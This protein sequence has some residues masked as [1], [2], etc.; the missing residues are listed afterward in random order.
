MKLLLNIPDLVFKIELL[1][2]LSGFDIV[3]LDNAILN[4]RYR[5]RIMDKLENAIIKGSLD[6][7]ATNLMLK[8]MRLRKLYLT[9]IRFSSNICFTEYMDMIN[10]KQLVRAKAIKFE[11]NCNVTDG[12]FTSIVQNCLDLKT[13]SINDCNRMSDVSIVSM[14]EMAKNLQILVL[15]ENY[16]SD[17]SLMSVAKNC[18]KLLKLSLI[19]CSSISDK[20]MKAVAEYC[21]ALQTLFLHDCDAITD[22]GLLAIANSCPE[23]RHVN[24]K[25][26]V[27]DRVVAAIAKTCRNL[28]SFHVINSNKVTDNSISYLTSRCRGVNVMN[29]QDCTKIT[30]ASILSLSRHC[31]GLQSLDVSNCWS[32]TDVSIISISEQCQR[33]IYLNLSGCNNITDASISSLSR[34]CNRLK[35]L[36]V[37][38]CRKITDEGILS[39]MER[40]G[41]LQSLD[42]RSCKKLTDRIIVAM[43]QSYRNLSFLYVSDIEKIHKSS[44][45]KLQ[46]KYPSMHVIM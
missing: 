36:D 40:C 23:L 24:F 13:V 38:Y 30:D 4:R 5:S 28:L 15:R 3:A 7:I 37:S 18:N 17:E 41:Q 14:S 31:V 45:K 16:L 11:K 43:I 46:L 32:I 20:S 1:K 19:D 39:L 6:I 21:H 29:L 34:N 44:L 2:Y 10:S 27:G 35:S 33:L 8:W 26:P 12:I 42:I 25:L 9:H 22:K